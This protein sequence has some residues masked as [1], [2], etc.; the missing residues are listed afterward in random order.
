MV[1]RSG[2][3]MAGLPLA[4]GVPETYAGLAELLERRQEQASRRHV[5]KKTSRRGRFAL[6]RRFLSTSSL[7][8]GSLF[9][10][11]HL[12]RESLSVH[13][14]LVDVNP[15][16]RLLA[17]AHTGRVLDVAVPVRAE[18]TTRH[19]RARQLHVVE[20]SARALENRHGDELRQHVV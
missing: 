12:L 11:D 7:D 17:G 15:T 8:V 20:H 6:S 19:T 1:R 9:H 14:E 13:N 18:I 2:R 16:R 5:K 4:T 3:I 10:D